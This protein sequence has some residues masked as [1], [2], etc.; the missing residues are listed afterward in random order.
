MKLALMLVALVCLNGYAQERTVAGR[1][2]ST[3]DGTPLPGVN[4]TIKGTNVGTVTDADGRYKLRV[5]IGA[6]LVYAFIGFATT[7]VVVT[8]DRLVPVASSGKEDRKREKK[9]HGLPTSLFSDSIN[10]EVPGVATLRGEK[11]GYSSYGTLRVSDI[12]SIK[13]RGGGYKLNIIREGWSS[14][15]TAQLTTSFGIEQAFRVPAIQSDYAQGR[16]EAG[17]LTWRGPDQQEIFSWGPSVKTLEFDGSSYPYDGNG[18]LVP[19]GGGNGLPANRYN[20][21]DF[22]R[23]GRFAASELLLFVPSFNRGRFILNVDH[24]Q[25]DGIV[26][27]SASEKVGIRL[28]LNQVELGRQGEFGAEFMFT[29]N[30]G[31]LLN[32]GANYATIMGSILRSPAT[33]D[34]ADGLGYD[35]AGLSAY[36]VAD[37]SI[38]SHAPGLAENPV[39]LASELPDRE[40]LNR[41]LGMIKVKIDPSQF[42]HV[43]LRASLDLQ[44]SDA[45]FGIPAGYSGV[46]NGR[47]TRRT[48]NDTQ[49]STYLSS[50]WESEDYDPISIRLTYGFQQRT[51]S[52]F[53]QDGFGFPAGLLTSP[54]NADTVANGEISLVRNS[55][56]LEGSLIY[57]DYAVNVR[58]GNRSYYSNTLPDPTSALFMPSASVSID[59]AELLWIDPFES[60]RVYANY[61]RSRQE[62][63][64][65]HMNWAYQSTVLPAHQYASYYESSELPFHSQLNPEIIQ[66][67]ETGT[68]FYFYYGMQFEASYFDNRTEDFIAPAFVNGHFQ[69]SNLATVS[70][71]GGNMSFSFWRRLDDGVALGFDLK[72][73]K[74]VSE[75]IST[76]GELVYPLSGFADVQS[77]LAPGQPLGTIYGSRYFRSAEGQLIIG[78][79]G[80]PVKDPTMRP[81]ASPIPD[82]VSGLTTNLEFRHFKFSCVLNYRHGGSVWNGTEAAMN[83]YGTSI[84]SASERLVNGYI[85]DGVTYDGD[86]NIIPVNFADPSKPVTENRWVRNGMDGVTE[87]SIQDGSSLR[88]S[89]VSL[90]YTTNRK[91]K[92]GPI[93]QLCFSLTGRNLFVSSPYR[94]VDPSSALFGQP[95]GNGLDMFNMPSTR[96]Y[97]AQLTLKL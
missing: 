86:Q 97:S 61:S 20:P 85:F 36:R 57:D 58:L 29:R 39:G 74:V 71:R 33:F 43:S 84:Q 40:S 35:H 90:S 91:F 66:K 53:R 26:R 82:W 94:G 64:L 50:I 22:F 48:D 21:V 34:N 30:T 67:F 79:E 70:N 69:L 19:A 8:T 44:Q 68:R 73:S 17:A 9:V 31:N 59:L 62:A 2:T 14:Q 52:V 11:P 89:E 16:P 56:E 28:N 54:E 63:Q 5:P 24:R 87:E 10:R 3:E 42:T 46:V 60:I 92:I 41:F 38:R 47:M 55:H 45:T 78:S 51:R 27:N 37:G 6:T 95:L 80:Y 25:S 18:R 65:L 81:I 83:Y 72:W 76:K 13:R 12:R 32:R 75:V 1:L 96:S 4:I 88:L 77:V 15:P 7:E 23:T 49:F 93:R